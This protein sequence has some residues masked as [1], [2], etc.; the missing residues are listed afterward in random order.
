MKFKH[1]LAYYIFGLAMGGFLVAFVF[2]KRGQ[3]FCYLP[4]C[5]VLKDLR[6]KPMVY[7][8]E[9]EKK[10]DE[11]WVTLDDIKKCTE[12]GDVDFSR[13]NTEYKGGGKLYFIE[14]K[15]S[16]DEP[17][18]VEMVNYPEKVLLKDVTKE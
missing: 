13:S 12:F 16:K 18:I 10:F 3:N 6:A 1:R 5:R 2:Q 7:S 9:I 17:I 15:N 14:G 11:K 4:N 8:K